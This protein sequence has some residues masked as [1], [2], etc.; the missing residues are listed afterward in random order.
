MEVVICHGINPSVCILKLSDRVPVD[1]ADEANLDVVLDGVDLGVIYARRCVE[2]M[3]RRRRL[4][5]NGQ[6]GELAL[7]VEWCRW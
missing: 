2:V 4:D 7:A 5:S 3:P 1:L 6:V